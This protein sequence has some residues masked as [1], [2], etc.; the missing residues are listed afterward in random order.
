MAPFKIFCISLLVAIAADST[1]AFADNACLG[2]LQESISYE[3]PKETILNKSDRAAIQIILAQT[4]WTNQQ[5]WGEIMRIYLAARIRYLPESVRPAAAQHIRLLSLEFDDDQKSDVNSTRIILPESFRETALGY[6]LQAHEWEHRLQN[7]A[8]NPRQTV[9]RA[10]SYRYRRKWNPFF[11]FRT[12]KFAMQVEWEILSLVPD[13]LAEESIQVLRQSNIQ[14]LY[15]EMMLRTF[16]NRHLSREEYVKAEHRAHRY[17]PLQV[18]GL[19]G[20]DVAQPPLYLAMCYFWY[21]SFG[22]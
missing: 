18:T 11:L 13:E 7:I 22:F 4:S 12:E 15:K 14:K 21:R 5:R 2:A 16:S 3:P 9:L 6:V 20:I 8:A 1:I 19:W 17:S 10:L